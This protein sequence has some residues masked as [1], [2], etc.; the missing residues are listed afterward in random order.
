MPGTHLPEQLSPRAVPETRYLAAERAEQYRLLLR[1][2]DERQRA[3]YATQLSV[4]D[5]FVAVSA[6]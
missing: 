5:V 1:V 6:R 3:E 2:F 4:H